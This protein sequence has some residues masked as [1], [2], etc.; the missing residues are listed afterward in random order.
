MAT[1]NSF[2]KRHPLATFFTLAFGMAWGLQPI[3]IA[4]GGDPFNGGP[5]AIVLLLITF[6]PGLAALIVLAVSHDPEESRAFKRRL[7]TWRVSPTWYLAAL[8]VGSAPWLIGAGIAAGLGTQIGF[9]LEMV[10]ATLPILVGSL[11]EELGWR[12]FALPRLLSRFSAVGASLIIGAAWSL[13]HLPPYLGEPISLNLAL[14]ACFVAMCA[15]QSITLTWL[16]QNTGGSVLLIIL[17]HTGLNIAAFVFPSQAVEV[18]ALIAL[19]AWLV[20]GFLI[21]RYGRNLTRAAGTLPEA[22]HLSQPHVWQS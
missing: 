5:A 10:T 14:F 20:A 9:R 12:N 19:V 21:V 3:F 4:L 13:W 1:I 6:T 7:L 22:R 2:V 18:R 16:Y 15:A 17:F 8:I 11:G